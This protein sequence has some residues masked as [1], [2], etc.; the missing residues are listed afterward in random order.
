MK[1]DTR[2]WLSLNLHMNWPLISQM[3]YDKWK[4][5]WIFWFLWNKGI[6]HVLEDHLNNKNLDSYDLIEQ[7]WYIYVNIKLLNMNYD[8]IDH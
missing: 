5:D 1:L 8:W 7:I 3:N 6:S 4:I 2:K